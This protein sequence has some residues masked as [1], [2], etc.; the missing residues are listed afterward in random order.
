MNLDG[1][2]RPG[3]RKIIWILN[4]ELLA[5]L[6]DFNWRTYDGYFLTYL[7]LQF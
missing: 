2:L 4:C 7:K 6:S 5:L 3:S 1:N